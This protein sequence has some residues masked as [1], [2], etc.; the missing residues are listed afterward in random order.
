MWGGVDIG[1][2]FDALSVS[3]NI[4]GF[5]VNSVINVII[6][7]IMVIVSFDEKKKLSGFMSFDELIDI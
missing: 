3:M 1:F 2:A 5:V 7:A 6:A 4:S